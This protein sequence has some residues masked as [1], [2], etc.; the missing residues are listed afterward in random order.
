L[1]LLIFIL[2]RFAF[3]LR[4]ALLCW[5]LFFTRRA[6]ETHIRRIISQNYRIGAILV[7]SFPCEMESIGGSPDR[8]DRY[9]P[10]PM[11]LLEFLYALLQRYDIAI[12]LSQ[13]GAKILLVPK[14]SDVSTIGINSSLLI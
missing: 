4:F 10:L 3:P 9:Q 1:F 11:H 14:V 7:G 5:R 12:L 2:Y 13:V 6:D 8:A